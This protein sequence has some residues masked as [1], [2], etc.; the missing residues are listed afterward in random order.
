LLKIFQSCSRLRDFTV[1]VPLTGTA[2]K[3]HNLTVNF[4]EVDANDLAKLELVQTTAQILSVTK[5]IIVLNG[6]K[7]RSVPSS[8]SNQSMYG[9]RPS[10]VS[11]ASNFTQTY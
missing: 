3:Q 4:C 8:P 5:V 6:T 9:T 7:R 10:L 1:L 2:Q 11:Y